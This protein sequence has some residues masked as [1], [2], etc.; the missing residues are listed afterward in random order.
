M[1]TNPKLA[2]S[3]IKTSGKT[4][5]SKGDLNDPVEPIVISDN[6]E[7]GAALDKML[8]TENLGSDIELQK[9]MDEQMYIR[10][11]KL[12][13]KFPNQTIEDLQEAIERSMTLVLNASKN[14]VK[15]NL[16]PKRTVI[17]IRDVPEKVEAS[18]IRE[19]IS[20]CPTISDVGSKLKDLH[21]DENSHVWFVNFEEENDARDCTLW[22]QQESSPW[23]EGKVKCGMKSDHLVRSFFPAA[24][25]PPPMPSMLDVQSLFMPGFGF[26]LFG[27]PFKGKGKKGF[28]KKGGKK[29]PPQP[30]ERSSIE[31]AD[32]GLRTL[33]PTDRSGMYPGTFRKY[34]RQEI[35]DVGEKV[36]TKLGGKPHSFQTFEEA[37]GPHVKGVF[38]TEPNTTWGQCI[39]SGVF[40]VIPKEKRIKKISTAVPEAAVTERPQTPPIPASEEKKVE[41]TA[42]AVPKADPKAKVKAKAKKKKKESSEWSADWQTWESNAWDSNQQKSATKSGKTQPASGNKASQWIAKPKAK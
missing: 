28:G 27:L 14:A 19:L 10:L 41:S 33:D 42:P 20:R 6:T 3:A 11:D 18:Q 4:L 35:L 37:N 38:V 17:L 29:G 23:G 26:P 24:M 30:M 13:E 16:K 34:S 21:A 12:N 7:L 32:L 2:S 1:A 15:P 22:L 40:P 5:P 36:R 25:A 8:S 31:Q 39:L 9:L